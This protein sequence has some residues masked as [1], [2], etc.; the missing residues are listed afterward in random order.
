MR[1]HKTMR[2]RKNEANTYHSSSPGIYPN[3]KRKNLPPHPAAVCAF[4][5]RFAARRAR[6]ASLRTLRSW[7]HR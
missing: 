2:K 6:R 1:E 3:E 5:A 4:N 7:F